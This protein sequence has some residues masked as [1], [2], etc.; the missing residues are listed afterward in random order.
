LAQKS[1]QTSKITA[2]QEEVMKALN[3]IAP[4]LLLSALLVIAVA[5]N[6]VSPTASLPISRN[7]EVQP[8]FPALSLFTAAPDALPVSR[9]R[10]VVSESS[11]Y[12]F[13]Q[14]DPC[15]APVSRSANVCNY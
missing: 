6:A 4:S 9:N 15:A 14:T 2:Q 5:A 12:A 13:T 3:W 8:V 7:L 1:K 10:P 11:N